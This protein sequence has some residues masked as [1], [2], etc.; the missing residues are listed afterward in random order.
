MADPDPIAELRRLLEKA[1]PGPW[2]W[3]GDPPTLYAGRDGMHHGANLLG[4]LEP[5]ADTPANLNLI[6]AV[7]DALPALLDIADAAQR[8]MNAVGVVNVVQTAD[9]LNAALSRLEGLKP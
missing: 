5:D 1:T 9:E 8:H 3:E 7:R 4:R 2:S 6:V